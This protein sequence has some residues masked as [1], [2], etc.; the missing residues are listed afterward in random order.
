MS[1][2][3]RPTLNPISAICAAIL[4]EMVDF[5][6]PP[7]PEAKI[8]FFL[9]EISQIYSKTVDF[10]KAYFVL[11]CGVSVRSVITEQ[12]VILLSF[13]IIDCHSALIFLYCS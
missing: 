12:L 2:S 6:T 3:I 1:A 13:S 7:L 8:I 10:L 4:L 9:G 5:P 11:G